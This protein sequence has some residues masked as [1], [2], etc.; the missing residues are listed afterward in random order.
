MS[1]DKEV[2]VDLLQQELKILDKALGYLNFALEQVSSID[3][4]SDLSDMDYTNLDSFSSRYL[5]IYEVLI[6]QVIRTT[7]TLLNEKKESNWDNLN[8]A[9]QLD[10]ITSADQMDEVR[11]FRNQVAHEYLEEEWPAIYR[12]LIISSSYIIESCI[13]TKKYAERFF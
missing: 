7:L 11:K 10:L 12:N 2:L 13:K 3:L 8:K 1:K 9:E 5:R 6:N 4:D